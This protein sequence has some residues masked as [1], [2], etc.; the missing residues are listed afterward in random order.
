MSAISPRLRRTCRISRTARSGGSRW[1]RR[2]RRRWMRISSAWSTVDAFR[3]D[4]CDSS[5]IDRWVL[6]NDPLGNHHC[7]KDAAAN[8][9]LPR[10]VSEAERGAGNALKGR[11]RFE[12]GRGRW[13]AG[14]LLAACLLV[15]AGAQQLNARD[16]QLFTRVHP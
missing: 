10:T 3:A 11:G 7:D 2:W 6:D 8:G 16:A 14:T 4:T 5:G 12:R 9:D 15:L 13:T 1:R